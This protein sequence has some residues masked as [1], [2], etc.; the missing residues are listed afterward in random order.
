MKNSLRGLLVTALGLLLAAPAG[1]F[2]QAATDF[3]ISGH[4]KNVQAEWIYLIYA[5]DGRQTLD[6]ARANNGDYVF[7]GIVSE[8]SQATLLDVTPIGKK[9][10]PENMVKIY[11][12]PGA[13]AIT[14][15]DSFSNTAFVGSVVNTDFKKIQEEAS[16]YSEREIALLPR[17]QAARAANDAPAVEAIK[18]QVKAIDEELDNKVYGPYVKNHSGTPLALYVLQL[19]RANEPEALQLQPLFDGLSSSVKETRAG[20][21]FEQELAIVAQTSIGKE[22]TDFT[23]NDTSGNPVKLSSFRGKYVLLDFWASW[24]GP[25]RMENPTV[26]STYAK[27]HPRGF[28]I[29]SVSLDRPGDKDK[30]LKAIH[31]DKL[32]WTHVSDLQ[33]WNN[34]VAKEYGVESI[35]QNFLIDPQGKIIA[36][37]L[38][39]DQLEK[40]LSKIYKN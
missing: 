7:N 38:R 24:C 40:R 21:D 17:Y 12:I 9:P 14:H 29:L 28:E 18:Q 11:L 10:L 3:R 25:C 35:P 33:F 6:S 19:Y 4:L 36:K 34:A 5:N 22:A 23:Q 1:L 31:A 20:K 37:G 32:T 26:V 15:T 27:Y 13:F 16:P 8:S 30:W 2:A 39:G